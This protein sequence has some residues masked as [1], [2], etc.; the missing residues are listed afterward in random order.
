MDTKQT[1]DKTFKAPNFLI[2]NRKELT[3]EHNPKS[4]TT[5]L[6][7]AES[8]VF[9]KLEPKVLKFKGFEVGKS[10]IKKFSIIN[11]S[12]VA[13]RLN[14]LPMI[15]DNFQFFFE[16][17][18]KIAP[19]MSE[20]VKVSFVPR[21]YNYY[22]TQVRILGENENF[23]IPIHAFPV[24]N[25]SDVEIFPRRVDFGHRQIH[26]SHTIQKSLICKI[27]VNFEF[28]FKILSESEEIK[29]NP[30]RGIVPGDSYINI[31]IVFTPKS[32]TTSV[33]E[34]EVC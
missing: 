23:I 25:R 24:M 6:E 34:A 27:P 19:G 22:H 12:T 7:Q 17:K 26:K 11:T 20:E 8:L 21:N 16:K 30:L 28:E 32:N 31:D 10:N 2:R 15:S 1:K 4:L 33:C 13:Q 14:I 3:V 29:I 9:F 5:K 18:G